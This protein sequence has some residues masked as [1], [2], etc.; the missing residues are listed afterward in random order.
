MSGRCLYLWKHR[1]GGVG[2]QSLLSCVSVPRGS[3]RAAASLAP[4]PLLWRKLEGQPRMLPSQAE[5]PNT[6]T[7]PTY[8]QLLPT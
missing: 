2:I 4:T 5:L 6:T 8:K 1:K 3:C 7:H